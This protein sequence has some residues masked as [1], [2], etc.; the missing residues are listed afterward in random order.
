MRLISC[1]SVASIFSCI[2]LKCGL[3]S[4]HVTAS[5][6]FSL[7][8]NP[9]NSHRCVSNSEKNKTW[10]QL[11]HLVAESCHRVLRIHQKWKQRV[12]LS[13]CE[14]RS[15][16]SSTT[17]PHRWS[18]GRQVERE[19]CTVWP[20]GRRKID[21]L[22]LWKWKRRSKQADNELLLFHNQTIIAPWGW[23]PLN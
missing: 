16:S 8:M 4:E 10:Q 11:S 19:T 15:C 3:S 6:S 14:R 5:V 1:V 21:L 23:L 9:L 2:G 22:W 18:S 12:N 7:G 13:S 17:L 20:Q